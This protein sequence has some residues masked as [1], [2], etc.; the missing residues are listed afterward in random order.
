[1]TFTDIHV[2]VSRNYFGTTS[3]HRETQSELFTACLQVVSDVTGVPP[4][5]IIS[6]SRKRNH[7]SAR[8]HLIA[9]IYALKPD[10]TLKSVGQWIGGR[11]H[12]TIINSNHEWY[13]L[14]ESHDWHRDMWNRIKSAY[15]VKYQLSGIPLPYDRR[16][17]KHNPDSI[18]VTENQPISTF[19]SNLYIKDMPAK[20]NRIDIDIIDPRIKRDLEKQKKQKHSRVIW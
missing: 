17:R 12:A 9:L 7:V 1:M 11:D 13:D 3:Q 15:C 4:N 20:K 19:K 2:A 8:H 6:A 10:A 16:P 18:P 5:H 14:Y